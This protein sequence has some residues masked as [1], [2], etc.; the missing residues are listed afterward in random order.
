MSERRGEALIALRIVP[1]PA[2]D[3]CRSPTRI[4][5]GVASIA[6]VRRSDLRRK[7][8]ARN[9]Q[10]VVVAR[11]DHHVGLGWHVTGR[12]LRTRASGGMV[13]M[14]RAIELRR[15]MTLRADRIAFRPKLT[16]VRLVTIA[17]GHAVRIHFALEKRSPVVD[18]IVLLPVG[19][20]ERIGEKRRP[21][22]IEKYLAGRIAVGDLAATRMTL[23]TNIDLAL[24]RTW[25]R[26]V[27]GRAHRVTSPAYAVPLVELGGE[28]FGGVF[29][30][31]LRVATSVRP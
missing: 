19:V 14:R 3:L 23:R 2:L 27:R 9:P 17:A 25:L 18:L 13:M 29:G 22:V 16:A 4:A 20:I 10:A 12:A 7:I 1:E 6:G 24:G 28:A 8:R 31:V 30:C 21:V 5:G 11:I 26:E 15:R